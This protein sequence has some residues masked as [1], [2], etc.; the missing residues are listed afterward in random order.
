LE[1]VLPGLLHSPASH[2]LDA[3]SDAVGRSVALDDGQECVLE[4]DEQIEVALAWTHEPQ[5]LSLCSALS[6]AGEPL[7]IALLQVVLSLNY[8]SMPPGYTIALDE[9][10]RQL[11]L[12]AMIDAE[13]TSADHFLSLVAGFLELVPRLREQ[14]AAAHGH[15][16][17]PRSAIE[18][19]G[20]A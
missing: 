7:D 18:M 13:S 19:G 14:C 6:V 3:L 9:S 11:V 4:F 1:V 20:F 5:V 12:V 10:N 8:S 17:E 2:L 16:L 15:H